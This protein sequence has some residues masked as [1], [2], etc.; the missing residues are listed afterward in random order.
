MG[1]IADEIE[2][3]MYEAHIDEFV[4]NFF[5]KRFRKVNDGDILVLEI[6]I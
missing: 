3:A 5:E 1:R 2:T 4:N 6:E